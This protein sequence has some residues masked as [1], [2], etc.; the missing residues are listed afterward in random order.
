MNKLFKQILQLSITLITA[1]LLISCTVLLKSRNKP[2][3]P[4]VKKE[5]TA[6][7]IVSP[8]LKDAVNDLQD[9]KIKSE[10]EYGIKLREYEDKLKEI[11]PVAEI[12]HGDEEALAAMKSAV[13]GH[14]LALE[15][16]QCDHLTGYDNLHQ[17]RDKALQGI[18]NKYPEIKEQALA[19]AQEE[20]SSYT[21]A[22]LDQQSLLEAIWSQANGDTAIAHQI[23]YPPLDIINTAA[24]EK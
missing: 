20:G 3:Q 1:N 16:W 8:A 22:E 18:F 24:E 19:I 11:V 12:A 15:F 13:E 5:A 4:E 23:I 9:L 17:C 7:P 10:G 2:K 14:K 6:L 21:S